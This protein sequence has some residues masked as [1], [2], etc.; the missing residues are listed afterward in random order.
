MQYVQMIGNPEIKQAVELQ[1]LF[2]YDLNRLIAACL[3]QSRLTQPEYY[4]GTQQSTHSQ[5][6]RSS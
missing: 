4:T 1:H 5:N 6:S 2:F 3:I